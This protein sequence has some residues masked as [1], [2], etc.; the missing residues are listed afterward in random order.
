M[1]GGFGFPTLLV[2]QPICKGPT[3]TE[4]YITVRYTGQ[5]AFRVTADA[6]SASPTWDTVNLPTATRTKHTFVTSGTEVKFMAIGNPGA[7]IASTKKDSGAFNQP[8]IKIEI[9]GVS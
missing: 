3:V 4:V 5:I 1:T 8:G 7:N 2:T 9:T 6:D